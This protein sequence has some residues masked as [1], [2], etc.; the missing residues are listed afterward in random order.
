VS[1]ACG[2]NAG[3]QAEAPPP[4]ASV[5]A[6]A[7]PLAEST[8]LIGSESGVPCGE[9][10]CRRFET[11]REAFRHVLESDPLVLGIGEAHALA[12]APSVPT[13][14][15]HFSNKLLPELNG[16]ASHLIVELLQPNPSCETTTREVERIQKPVTSAQSPE[17]QNDYVELG[18]HAR[19]LGIEPF[20]LSPTCDELSAIAQAGADAIGQTLATIADVTARMVPAALMQ[21]QRKGHERIVIAYGGALHNDESP[22]A[23]HARW[24]YAPRLLRGTTGRYIALDLIVR[25]FIKDTDVWR[26]QPWYEQFDRERDPDHAI[27]M[28]T[29]PRSYV[30]FFPRSKSAA[31]PPR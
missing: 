18:H 12:D 21:N 31:A 5:E 24:S 22:D 11:A 6:P 7:A 1:F 3:R 4:A 16:R 28:R 15:R 2:G 13:T 19:R 25:E 27:S 9:L 8:A 26:A 23:A 20:V 10:D 29:G 30:L 14:A 17:N